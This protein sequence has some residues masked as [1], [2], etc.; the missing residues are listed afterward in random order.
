MHFV[1]STKVAWHHGGADVDELGDH[2]HDVAVRRGATSLVMVAA[3]TSRLV[4]ILPV[5]DLVRC[6]F[7]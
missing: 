1:L 3:P 4:A 6:D 7:R 2:G 5:E